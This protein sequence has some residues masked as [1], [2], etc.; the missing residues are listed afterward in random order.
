MNSLRGRT[1][2]ITRNEA[3]A[4]EF[5][6]IVKSEGGN[7][8]ALEAIEIVPRGPDA[9]RELVEQIR[10]KR[11]DYCAFM[12][13]QA[14]DALF[15]MKGSGKVR[16]LLSE[17]EVIAVGPRT[18]D[19]LNEHGVKASLTPEKFSSIGLVKMMSQLKPAGKK[20]IIPR[21]AAAGDYAAI[22]LRSLG[23][24]VDEVIMYDVKPSKTS[25]RWQAFAKLLTE[26]NV[27]AIIF[28]SASNVGAFFEILR[29]ILPGGV[30]LDKLTKVVSIGPF[31][32][33]ELRAR[34]VEP[35]EA[36]EHTIRGAVDLTKS[37]LA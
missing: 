31:T 17:T 29:S 28:T 26:R 10:L 23:M 1:I 25:A 4:A 6:E 19:R 15:D 16:E 5:F 3:D 32:S 12:S 34:N 18:S 2:A 11:H 20:I 33:K 22:A 14:V 8:V 35:F 30:E 37:L 9:A 7:P 36:A 24:S 13:A 27:D 21:S